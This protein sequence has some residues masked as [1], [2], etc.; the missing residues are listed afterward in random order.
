MSLGTAFKTLL[1]VNYNSFVLTVGIIIGVALYS[2]EGGGYKEFDSHAR[3]MYGNSHIEGTCVLL[4]I[5]SMHKLVKYFRSLFRN[6]DTYE[7]KGV[8]IA[9]FEVDLS[10][11]SVEYCS[12]SNVNTVKPVL[13]GYPLLSEQW[14]KSPNL[15]PLF[16][17]N[18]TFIKRTSILSERGHLKST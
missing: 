16:T 1:A 13:S 4:E 5:P 3:D 6:E 7:L 10:S 8:H 14:P 17:L 12:I 18:E 9:N 11:S 15:F 2:I